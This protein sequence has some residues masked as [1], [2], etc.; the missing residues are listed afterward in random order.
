M[1]L[2]NLEMYL[3]IPLLLLIL[4][5]FTNFV[6]IIT[7]GVTLMKTPCSFRPWPRGKLFTR[8]KVKVEC[9]PSILIRPLSFYFLINCAILFSSLLLVS[10]YGTADLAIPT[11][12]FLSF[13]YKIM[14]CLSIIV[15]ILSILV[16]T[17]FMEKCTDFHFLVQDL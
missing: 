4:L 7:V 1:L 15:L 14:D 9:T 13:C 10:I 6:M 2:F 11:L 17:I 12:K 16:F 8:S 5:Q 3:G